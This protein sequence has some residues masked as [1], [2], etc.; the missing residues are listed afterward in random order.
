MLHAK[1]A[2][3]DGRWARVGSTNLN[4]ASWFGNF[5]MDVVVEDEPFAVLMEQMFLG[6][7]ANATEIVLDAKKKLRAPNEPRHLYPVLTRGGGSVGRAAAGA[8]RIAN[9]VAAAF[10]NRRVL[11]PVEARITV[12]VGATL[13]TLATL[14]AFFPRLL[15]YPLVPLL[16]WI[17]CALLYRGYKLHRSKAQQESGASASSTK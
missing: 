10:T 8:V 15:A 4:I 12:T 13:L 2:V 14:F 1:T 11:E 5:E 3:A 16:T 7:L 6:D 9:V 17:S